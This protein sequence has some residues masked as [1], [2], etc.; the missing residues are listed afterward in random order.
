[1]FP[2]CC[3]SF[4]I[5]QVSLHHSVGMKIGLGI[6]ERGVG[7]GSHSSMRA[8]QLMGRVEKGTSRAISSQ[9][10]PSLIW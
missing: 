5:A 10:H 2:Y 3:L 1:M 7:W 8:G 6:H 4:S 9:L